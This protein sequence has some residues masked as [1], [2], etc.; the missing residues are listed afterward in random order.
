M[1]ST[2]L[3]YAT[4]AGLVPS[5][6]WLVFWIREDSAQMEPRLMLIISFVAG[7]CVVAVALFLEQYTAG[8]IIG[9]T[10]RYVVWAA[11]E[12]LMKF[13][14][15]A[16]VALNT[17]WNDEPIDAMIYCIVV[18]LGFAAV[19]NTLFALGPLSAG[20]IAE[21]IVND[22]MR[23]IGATLVHTVSSALPGFALGWAFYRGYLTKFF[24]LILG[25][26]AAVALH[27]AFNLSIINSVGADT[28]RTFAWVWG[29]VV[30]LIVLFEEVKAVQ[31]RIQ[32]I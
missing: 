29:A 7:M 18:A 9:D 17:D 24:A 5:L 20:S 12:E 13:T 1:A 8:F 23:F 3:I 27:A 31:P 10:T 11:I 28:L 25:L 30:I 19:E 14:A 15:V 32:K 21:S 4:I 2:T 6:I 16:I 22:N 26:S